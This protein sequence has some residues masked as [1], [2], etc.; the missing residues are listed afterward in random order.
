MLPRVTDVEEET[1]LFSHSVSRLR[2]SVVLDS[3]ER[4]RIYDML[5]WTEGLRNIQQKVR[6]MER[7]MENAPSGSKKE[8]SPVVISDDTEDSDTSVYLSSDARSNYTPSPWQVSKVKKIQPSVVGV[9]PLPRRT[10]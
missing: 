10:M 8:A 6:S 1:F 2:T 3:D 4:R 9:V 7:S 5:E